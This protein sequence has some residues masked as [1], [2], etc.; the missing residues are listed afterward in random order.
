MWLM[1]NHFVYLN[2]GDVIKRGCLSEASFGDVSQLAASLAE[3]KRCLAPVLFMLIIT[4]LVTV[5]RNNQNIELLFV[6]LLL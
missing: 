1:L 5:T 6:I 4:K 2:P 3:N